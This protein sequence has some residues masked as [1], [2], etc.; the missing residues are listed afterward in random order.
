M[1]IFKILS[2]PFAIVSFLFSITI[3]VLVGIGIYGW[4]FN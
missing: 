2:L 3:L 1:M 4:L